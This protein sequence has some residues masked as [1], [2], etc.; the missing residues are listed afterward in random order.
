MTRRVVHRKLVCQHAVTIDRFLSF[1]HFPSFLIARLISVISL[2][3][4]NQ[5][6][7]FF[8]TA[9]RGERMQFDRERGKFT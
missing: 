7:V 5:S 4:Y 3:L 2:P 8:L 9:R 1:E 6:K